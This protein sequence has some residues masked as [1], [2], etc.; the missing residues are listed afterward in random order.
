MPGDAGNR[1][2]R[3]VDALVIGAGPAGAVAARG[4]AAR[5]LQVLLV[6]RAKFPR[7]KVCGCCLS[8]AALRTL[9]EIHL[10][11]LPRQNGAI[12]IE[13][14]TLAV[15]RISATLELDGGVALSR[16]RFDNA[17][18]AEAVATGVE[19]HQETSAKWIRETPEGVCVRLSS[20]HANHQIHAA[21]VIAADG[22]AGSFTRPIPGIRREQNRHARIG[23]GAA[24]HSATHAFAP[25]QIHMSIGSGGY[26]GIVH[27]ADGERLNIAAAFDVAFVKSSGGMAQAA[28][29]ILH[30]S[31]SP[32]LSE[33]ATAHWFGTPPLTHQTRPP[34]L[35]RLFLV[36]DAA[37]YVEPFTGEGMTWAL[38]SGVDVV[39]F[40]VAAHDGTSATAHNDWC[41]HRDASLGIQMRN[42]RRIARVLRY[43]RLAKQCV[44][45]LGI[46]PAIA[47]PYLKSLASI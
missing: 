21:I 29:Q 8:G 22:L 16:E 18:V 33:L 27:I 38:A 24:V 32:E 44:R 47:R 1:P 31:G 7:W 30:E 11:D 10:G 15:R 39:P 41:M 36:G 43:P 37:G 42:C 25:G 20:M 5:G 12:A 34:P 35:A 17:L 46:C 14:V 2:V 45:L 23:A 40:A 26:V 19:F 6:D 9:E 13:R 28:I 3:V 4:L